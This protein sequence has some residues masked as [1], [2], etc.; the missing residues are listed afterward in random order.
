ME[1]VGAMAA[2]EV[3]TA[4]ARATAVEWDLALVWVTPMPTQPRLEELSLPVI[5]E[6]I[7]MDAVWRPTGDLAMQHT[8][9]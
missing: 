2:V 8:I 3:V 6:Q 7:T 1:V 5:G 9:R 4:A